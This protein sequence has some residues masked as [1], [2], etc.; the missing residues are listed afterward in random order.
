MYGNIF[1]V[2]E[3][4]GGSPP[5]TFR[6]FLSVVSKLDDPAKPVETVTEAHFK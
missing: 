3:A 1:S 5:L 4:N 2:I 6:K